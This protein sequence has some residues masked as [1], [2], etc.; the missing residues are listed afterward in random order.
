MIHPHLQQPDRY[1]KAGIA[2]RTWNLRET[3]SRDRSQGGLHAGLVID[4]LRIGDHQTAVDRVAWLRHEW[5]AL[6]GVGSSIRV[7]VAHA[8]AFSLQ[9][10]KESQLSRLSTRW[11]PT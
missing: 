4:V 10:V 9:Y 1:Q 6:P 11:A 3:R 5:E 8:V 7:E 2:D